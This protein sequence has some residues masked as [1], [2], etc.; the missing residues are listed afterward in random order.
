MTDAF[1]IRKLPANAAAGVEAFYNKLKTQPLQITKAT[2][3]AG[4]TTTAS[5]NLS[6][7]PAAASALDALNTQFNTQIQEAFT[8]LTEA[9]KN[10][11]SSDDAKAAVRGHDLEYQTCLTQLSNHTTE[12]SKKLTEIFNYE[13]AA[14]A[15]LAETHWG[16]TLS[17]KERNDIDANPEESRKKFVEHMVSELQKRQKADLDNIQRSYDERKTIL[18]NRRFSTR[19][20]AQRLYQMYRNPDVLKKIADPL[21]GFDGYGDFSCS[22]LEEQLT[23]GALVEHHVIGVEKGTGKLVTGKQ[24]ENNFYNVGV[25]LNF[26]VEK[27]QKGTMSVT[28][29]FDWPPK[30]NEKPLASALRNAK[31]NIQVNAWRAAFIEQ[32]KDNSNK[33]TW[34]IASVVRSLSTSGDQ[35]DYEKTAILLAE[36][37]YRVC[38]NAQTIFVGPVSEKTKAI[39]DNPEACKVAVTE[40]DGNYIELVFK[41]V[42]ELDLDYIKLAFQRATA[43]FKPNLPYTEKLY[44][45]LDINPDA[46]V[47]L[48]ISPNVQDMKAYSYVPTMGLPAASIPGA[49]VVPLAAADGAAAVDPKA[50][51]YSLALSSKSPAAA[52]GSPLASAASVLIDSP[53]AKPSVPGLGSGGSH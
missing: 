35:H 51:P 5:I 28:I 1:E 8:T 44:N 7:Y 34:D 37:I 18:D 38:P 53:D 46:P 40:L 17:D 23:K 15:Q 21:F 41:T 42:T 43:F 6:A 26:K 16:T 31:F 13:I 9:A 11:E 25:S 14:V 30:F 4:K 27:D 45:A 33:I 10:I 48:D 29:N 20:N 2:D 47:Q 19:L 49:S 39:I 52:P 12:T 32:M 22:A 36:S 3:K 24:S 50:P